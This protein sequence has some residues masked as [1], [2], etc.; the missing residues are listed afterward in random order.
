MFNTE[1]IQ[2]C[3]DTMMLKG[4]HDVERESNYEVCSVFADEISRFGSRLAS[5]SNMHK[6]TNPSDSYHVP[7]SCH[8][9]IATFS[10]RYLASNVLEVCRRRIQQG[11]T[12]YVATR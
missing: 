7:N 5:K 1:Y 6:Q 12:W 4:H 3:A 2:P 8:I 10:L 11:S 9:N